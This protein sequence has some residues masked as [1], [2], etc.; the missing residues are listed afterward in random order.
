MVQTP[1]KPAAF[2]STVLMALVAIAH[3]LRLVLRVEVVAGGVVV[4]LWVSL[5]GFVVPGAL[6]A[7]LWRESR[8]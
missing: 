2:L 1:R 6:A 3:L 4:P 7:A 5:V 8:A